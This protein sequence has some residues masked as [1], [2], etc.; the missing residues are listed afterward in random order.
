MNLADRIKT[1]ITVNNLTTSSFADKIGVQRSGVS[2][3][4]N[5]RNRPSMDFL[6][7]V[8]EAF[9]RVDAGWLL[10]GKSPE[11]P[12]TQ[13]SQAP[14]EGGKPSNPVLEALN[15][16]SSKERSIEKIVIFYSDHTFETYNP[17]S[18]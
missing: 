14:K 18:Q 13:M 10:T 4:L 2:H 1:I 6:L 3:I 16:N 15:S 5:G 7:K 12:S 8:V 17:S 9:P 11:K